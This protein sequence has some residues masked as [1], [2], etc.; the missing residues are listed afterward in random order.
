VGTVLG[1]VDDRRR[2]VVRVTLAERD[3]SLLALVDTG[4]NGDLH[5]TESVALRFGFERTSFDSEV[6]LA[7]GNSVKVVRGRG[8][9]Q[10]LG[11]LR[12]VQVFIADDPRTHP[13]EGEPDALLG[14][15]LLSPHVLLVDFTAMTIEIESQ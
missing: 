13:R 6:A 2:P 7:D 12:R 10:W 8:T 14:T 1:G 9:I 5:V 3:E 11:K 15:G 4:F